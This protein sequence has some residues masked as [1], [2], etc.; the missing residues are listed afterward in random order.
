MIIHQL[1]PSCTAALRAALQ[2]G[3]YK[4]LSQ[5]ALELGGRW[6]ASEIQAAVAKLKRR[7][8]VVEGTARASGPTG[9]RVVKA[10]ALAG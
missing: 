7:S 10:Y 6:P 2:P 9:R 3:R 4:T 5:L 8:I 1:K